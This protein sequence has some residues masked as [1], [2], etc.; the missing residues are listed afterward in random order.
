MSNKGTGDRFEVVIKVLDD[1]MSR[2]ELR[3][4]G[5]GKELHGRIEFYRHSG[6]VE[7]ENGQRWWIYITCNSCGYQNSWWKLLR[8]F[9]N[10]KRRE[11]GL[12]E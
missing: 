2:G 7:D 5:C 11:A 12:G 1:L 6:G 9:V 8:Q 4:I 3:C 10:R